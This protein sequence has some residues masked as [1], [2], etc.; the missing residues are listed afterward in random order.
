MEQEKNTTALNEQVLQQEILE[1][2]EALTLDLSNLS[3]AEILQKFIQMVEAD[4]KTD[5]LKYGESYKAAFY[6][7]LNENKEQGESNED[8]VSDEE[9]TFKEFYAQYKELKQKNSQEQEKAKEENYLLKLKVIEELKALLDSTEDLNTTIPAFRE[10]QTRWKSID[11]VPQSKVKELWDTY[12]HCVEKFYD[13]IKINNEFRDLDFKKNL[14]AKTLLCEKAE[15]LEQEG[16]IVI[17]FKELQKLHQEWKELGPVAKEH[18]ESIWD[19]FKSVTSV[20][21]KKHQSFFE[22]L[23]GEQK[24]N[25][26]AKILICEQA[27]QI[28]SVFPDESSEWNTLSKQMED[29]Q[30][31]WKTIGFAAKKD[32]QKIYDRF[33]EACDKFYNSKREYYANFKNVMQD[34]LKRKEQLCEQAEALINSEDWKKATDQLINLQK[35]WKEVGPV[36]RKQSDIVWKRFRAACDYFFERKSAHFGKVDEGYGNNLKAKQDLIAE[37]KNYKLSDSKEDNTLAMREFQN[38]WNEIGFVPFADKEKVQQEFNAAMDAHFADIRSL[39]SEKK[40]NKFKKMVMEVKNSSKGSRG[41]KAERE[42]LMNKYRKI[43]QDI[44]TFENNIGFFSKS[45]GADALISDV[46]RKVAIAKEELIHIE[47][48]IQIIDKQFE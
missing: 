26:E 45:K 14:E 20:I 43:E 30:E 9:V 40:L 12:Q 37:I 23:K 31:K 38:R 46:R 22:K 8:S 42:K 17:A 27:E 33:R 13:Y 25:L 7:V 34:N 39:D 32:N 48:K 3:L 15:A 29:L 35:L 41:L 24:N 44:A 28:A 18:R 2:N 11:M 10:L 1:S 36:A 5:L 21:N 47:E 19:R 6:K 16:N 4:D